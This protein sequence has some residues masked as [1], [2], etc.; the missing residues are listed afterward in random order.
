MIPL[1]EIRRFGTPGRGF[2]R[3][4]S[5][6]VAF[7]LSLFAASS[8][9]G[10]GAPYLVKDINPSASGDSFPFHL[11]AV[12]NGVFFAA[13]DGTDGAEPWASDGSS[14]GTSLLNDIVSGS[15]S[16]MF[17]GDPIVG[18]GG[19]AYFP[20]RNS[21]TFNNE[22]WRS[23]GTVLGTTK[24]AADVSI[25]D[26][27]R[28]GSSL[29]FTAT[30]P[31][32][33]GIRYLFTSDGT[34]GG[35]QAI[36][37]VAYSGPSGQYLT[38]AGGIAYFPAADDA[39]GLELWRSDGTTGGT[40]KVKDINVGAFGSSPMLLTN[41]NGMLYFF[42]DD[43]GGL[44]LWRSDGTDAGTIK[45]GG[46]PTSS[47]SLPGPQIADLNGVAIAILDDGAHGAELW[48]SDGTVSGTTLIKDIN[49]GS[50]GGL[51][52]SGLVVRV[53]KVYFGADDGSTGT[54]LWQ[55][56][57]TAAGTTKVVDIN[58]YGGSFPVNMVNINGTL[59]FGA[60]DGSGLTNPWTSDGTAAGTAKLATM[61][62]G[63]SP[64]SYGFTYAGGT[65][66]FAGNDYSGKG[67][68]LWAVGGV[69][70]AG[71]A[72][73]A[74]K[75]AMELAESRPNPVGSTTTISYSLPVSGRVALDVFDVR[76]R[77]VKRV[78]DREESAGTHHVSLNVADW[79]N[80]VYFCRLN[81]DA[82]SLE[83]KIIVIH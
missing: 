18:L 17:A 42:A 46:S 67:V 62:A 31:T 19:V 80:G 12:G 45:L 30:T 4:G 28:I 79:S 41:V 13:N 10:F 50:A 82:H 81:A 56:D 8:A 25:Y 65:V 24:V 38:D 78:V 43:G 72:G 16:S 22:L 32:S 77:E 11:T 68:E 70:A 57:G 53:N 71:D 23:D 29:Y 34:P 36:T 39:Y 27:A 9:W 64:H 1:L 44:K 61:T 60:T 66:Y 40:V 76:G 6:C 37:G 55:S 63:G 3:L 52:Q 14:G 58:P 35:T 69:T 54:E 26:M 59:F 47:G 75:G 73:P 7:A 33:G 74:P 21:A 51:S 2:P 48:R 5:G 15:G 20:G 49:P 83:R